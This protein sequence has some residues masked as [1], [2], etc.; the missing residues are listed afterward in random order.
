MTFRLHTLVALRRRQEEQAAAEV[1]AL[2]RE[3][4][5]AEAEQRRLD[6][7]AEAARARA[8]TARVSQ[9]G[10]L[11]SSPGGTAAQAQAAERLA[12]RLGDQAARAGQAA[13]DHRKATLAAADAAEAA[14]RL[15][16]RERRQAR[17]AVERVQARAD[18]E[19]RRM[20]DRRAEY[21]ASD[22]RRQRP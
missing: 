15:A 3:R 10:S 5:A 17:E 9:S 6:D 1:V 8:V 19:Q 21:A 22:L 20:A 2:A 14:A 7:T 13:T 16:H 18:A 4:V 11:S 12:L